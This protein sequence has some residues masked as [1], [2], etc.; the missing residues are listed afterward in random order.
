MTIGTVDS[1]GEARVPLTVAG[2]G[3]K[4][5]RRDIAALLDTGA[6]AFGHDRTGKAKRNQARERKMGTTGSKKDVF[7]RRVP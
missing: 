2:P 1:S 3:P 7:T 6:T 4:E 5:P